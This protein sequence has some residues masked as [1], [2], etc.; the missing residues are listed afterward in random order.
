MDFDRTGLTSSARYVDGSQDAV[1]RLSGRSLRD[2]FSPAVAQHGE[3]AGRSARLEELI[4]ALRADPERLQATLDLLNAAAG[5]TTRAA[6]PNDEPSAEVMLI[7][8]FKK[9]DVIFV[10]GE[11]V[12]RG[13]AGCI[14]WRMLTQFYSTGRTVFSNR[15]LRLDLSIR[16]PE[17]AD[18]LES[19]LVLLQR[20]LI[21]RGTEIQLDRI[22]RGQMR[23]TLARPIELTET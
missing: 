22:G 5:F 16:L 6:Q 11:Y 17:K 2:P 8:R 9:N 4:E 20:R 23:L 14:F 1:L 15:E 12:I 3:E 18:N 19:R 7:R 21:A 13:L 10:D